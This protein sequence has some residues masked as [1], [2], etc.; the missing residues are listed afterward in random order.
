MI[1]IDIEKT[2]RKYSVQASGH[3]NAGPYGSDLVC[4]A[5]STLMQALELNYPGNSTRR[6]NSIAICI[7][8]PTE[9]DKAVMDAFTFA[10]EYLSID[11]PDN[12]SIKKIEQRGEKTK[13]NIDNET[14]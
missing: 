7:D 5:L 14:I 9:R 12:I 13:S 10:M 4:C 3:A 2:D 11:Y 1:Q 8:E 6:N